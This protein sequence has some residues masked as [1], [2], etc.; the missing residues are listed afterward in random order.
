MKK[1]K[2]LS[3]TK[4]GQDE[5]L[6]VLV[7]EPRRI[8]EEC[9]AQQL[10][11]FQGIDIISMANARGWSKL[12]AD[13]PPAPDVILLCIADG[14]RLPADVSE[15]V[16]GIEELRSSPV[17][18]LTNE[19]PPGQ[20]LDLLKAGVRG[21][22]P[23]DAEC[24]IVVQVL[25]LVTAGG[26]YVPLSCV[27]SLPNQSALEMDRGQFLT[28]RQKQVIEGIRL[29]KPNKIIAYELNMCE[30]TVK[31]HVRTI[32]KKLKARN[33]TEVAYLYSATLGNVCNKDEGMN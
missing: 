12:A 18:V 29:G 2:G 20:V 8:F 14:D 11:Q 32:M 13:N 21:V 6:T 26:T 16:A 4:V 24:A 17:V 15:V 27:N 7:I 23:T 1:G 33:R 30:S 5:R 25:R 10:T 28:E 19:R 31:V 3:S 22:I 9:L